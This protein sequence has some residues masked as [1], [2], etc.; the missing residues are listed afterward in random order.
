MLE[1]VDLWLLPIDNSDSFDIGTRL[2]TARSLR[3]CKCLGIYAM[4]REI[5]QKERHGLL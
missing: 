5:P 2:G 4:Y 1:T 3:Q